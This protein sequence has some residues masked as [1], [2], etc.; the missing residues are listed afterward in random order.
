[1]YLDGVGRVGG[2]LKTDQRAGIL[3]VGAPDFC[4]RLKWCLIMRTVVSQTSSGLGHIGDIDSVL[5]LS[6]GQLGDHGKEEETDTTHLYR[7]SV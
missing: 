6:R 4:S 5:G 3:L 2:G 1:M 7:F